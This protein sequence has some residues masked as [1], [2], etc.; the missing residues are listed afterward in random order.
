MR[1][2]TTQMRGI[3]RCVAVATAIALSLGALGCGQDQSAT[4]RTSILEEGGLAAGSILAA[5]TG[6]GGLVVLD[7]DGNEQMS[8][9]SP[10][11]EASVQGLDL[12]PDRTRAYV[13]F[14]IASTTDP[15]P[16]SVPRPTPEPIYE[17]GLPSGQAREITKG[18]SPAVSPDGTRL[19]YWKVEV[20]V[21]I[22]YRTALVVRTLSTGDETEYPLSKPAVVETPPGMIINW[23]PDG[24]RVVLVGDEGIELVD[25]KSDRGVPT[26]GVPGDRTPTGSHHLAPVFLDSNTLV[27]LENC[28]IGE[29]HL[30]TLDLGTGARGDFATVAG[31]PEAVRRTEDGDL[32]ITTAANVLLRVRSGQVR[33]VGRGYAAADTD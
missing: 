15:T 2:V 26:K 4:T 12:T 7:P 13:S 21:D 23:S 29:Q 5:K 11:P 20:A 24:T 6:A 8:V 22:P 28:C 30:V 10:D 27:V 33:G 9:P 31:P 16:D 3:P 32:L 19:A 25:L 17:I 14:Y 1:G 18:M